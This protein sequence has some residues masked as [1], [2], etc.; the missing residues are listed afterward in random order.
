MWVHLHVIGEPRKKGRALENAI[1]AQ[2]KRGKGNCEKVPGDNPI[3]AGE[4]E[5]RRARES[6][7]R[8]AACSLV[9]DADRRD[10]L[11]DLGRLFFDAE[12][13]TGS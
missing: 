3:T 7:F 8:R 6:S 5:K 12:P 2:G 1:M 4:R 9:R 11:N 10:S 13:D